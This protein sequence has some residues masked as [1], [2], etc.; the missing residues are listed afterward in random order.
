MAK[1]E[2]CPEKSISLSI[3]G[4]HYNTK[5]RYNQFVNE[6]DPGGKLYGRNLAGG[7]K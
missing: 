2:L 6:Q 4:L 5:K 7:G 3:L 1:S